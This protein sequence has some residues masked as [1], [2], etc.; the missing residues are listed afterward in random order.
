MR[1]LEF[2]FSFSMTL[3][4]IDYEFYLIPLVSG[5]NEEI[6]QAITTLG[7]QTFVNPKYGF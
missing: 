4:S 2:N 3:S 1:L 7:L 5:K 6:K